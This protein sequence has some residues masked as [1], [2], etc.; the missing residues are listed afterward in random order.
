MKLFFEIFARRT[1]SCARKKDKHPTWRQQTKTT[2][3]GKGRVDASC[4]KQL[5][6]G[7]ATLAFTGEATIIVKRCRSTI[8]HPFYHPPISP[9]NSLSRSVHQVSP[10]AVV[11]DDLARPPPESLARTNLDPLSSS[12]P[13]SFKVNSNTFEMRLKWYGRATRQRARFECAAR[14]LATRENRKD[15]TLLRF[16]FERETRPYENINFLFLS[17]WRQVE[18]IQTIF[19]RVSAH[20]SLERRNIQYSSTVFEY[21]Y[22]FFYLT[23]HAQRYPGLWL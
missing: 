15:L 16:S 17:K 14:K 19:E 12:L 22:R 10:L 20:E 5:E 7:S 4:G 23:L 1:A 21:L 3:Y 9:L 2:P 6:D 18:T 13:T 8:P 11:D